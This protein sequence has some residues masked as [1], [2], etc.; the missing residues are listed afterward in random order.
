MN[1]T[2]IIGLVALTS[3]A[4]PSFVFAAQTHQD[5]NMHSNMDVSQSSS[6]LTEPGQG[7]F[8]AISEIVKVLTADEDTDWSK[9]NLTKLRN[10]L[11]DMDILVRNATATQTIL[12]NGVS[13]KVT[14]D[15]EVLATAK[16][17]IPAHGNE[18]RSDKSWVVDFTVN[19]NDVIL[20]VTSEDPK[21]AQRIKALGFYGLMAS[22]D[23]H[24]KHHYII[25]TGGDA[26][27][28]H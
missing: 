21:V 17:M 24:R 28:G 10:H 14:G 27:S 4:I 3:L 9:V 7:A 18:L 12:E 5:H 8:A 11:I 19:D 13:T 6:L 22:Q 1:R 25:A 15:A 16:R 26:H 20:T 23:H 2:T